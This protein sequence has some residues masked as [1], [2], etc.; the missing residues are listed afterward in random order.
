[1]ISEEDEQLGVMTTDKAIARALEAGL[2]LVEVSPTARPPVCRIMDYG[3]FK[4]EQ[5]KRAK[6]SKKKQHFVQVKEVKFRP[7][8]EEHDYQ[9]KKKHAE[10]FLKK[11]NKVKFTV[12]FRGRALDH[13][14]M[15]MRILKRVAGE[16]SE[17]GIVENSAR[18]E[19]RL[20]TMMMAPLPAKPGSRP[21]KKDR[22]AK[23]ATSPPRGRKGSPEETK[24]PP[25]TAESPPEEA[26]SPP[27]AVESSVND[28]SPPGDAG[29]P[30]GEAEGSPS[31]ESPQVD[32]VDT[33][34]T[35]KASVER[36]GQ[37]AEDEDEPRSEKEIS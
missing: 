22:G 29:S 20:M 11:L 33:N 21:K 17:V 4:Y 27:G 31:E 37:N 1:V 12:I 24:S 23:S 13:K 30:P 18:F 10:G 14:E 16:R 2:D 5:N 36:E 26:K 28:K 7:K 19:G 6:E 35:G 9:F 32:A 15:G 8:T 34:E 3:Q 25:G